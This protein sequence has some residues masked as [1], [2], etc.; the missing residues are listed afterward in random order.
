MAFMNEYVSAEDAKKYDL[1]GINRQF[2]KE[3]QVRYSWTI[4]REQNVFLKWINSGKEEFVG[5]ETY[6]LWWKSYILPIYM[7]SES[8]GRLSEKTSTIWRLLGIELP[9]ELLEQRDEIVHVLKE[10]LTEYK[11]GVGIDVADHT[12]LFEF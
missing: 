12:A 3:P 4:D 6:V 1:D 8:K 5:R 2:G 7:E 9:T 10:A 11:V